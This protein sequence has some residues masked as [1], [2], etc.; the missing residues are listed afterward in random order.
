MTQSRLID[1]D[2]NP[3]GRF[4]KIS[5]LAGG[6]SMPAG[7]DVDSA[8]GRIAVVD[9]NRLA[10]VYFDREG[11]FLYEFGGSDIFSWPSEV[12][13]DSRGRVYVGDASGLVRVFAIIEES[14]E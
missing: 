1:L 13:L 12:A 7:I 2:G 4:G 11:N 14:I 3:I 8:G 9:M 10:I 6:F 5:G